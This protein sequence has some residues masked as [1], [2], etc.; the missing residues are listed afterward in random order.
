MSL[1]LG[2]FTIVVFVLLAF[3]FF[4]LLKASNIYY[5]SDFL[6]IENFFSQ[7]KFPIKNVSYINKEFAIIFILNY[8]DENSNI[9]ISRHN[10]LLNPKNLFGLF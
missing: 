5:D 3:V 9:K 8:H 2:F 7:I 4:I 1:I 6:Y 10:P